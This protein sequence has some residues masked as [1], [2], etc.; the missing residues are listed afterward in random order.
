MPLKKQALFPQI[1]S[2]SIQLRGIIMSRASI[3]LH[4]VSYLMHQLINLM[5]F[6]LKSL[7]V[8]IQ[9]PE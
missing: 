4:V 5:I 7:C 8:E 6:I 1:R 2:R 3:G 9:H